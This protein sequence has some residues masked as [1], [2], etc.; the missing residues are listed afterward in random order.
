MKLNLISFFE[1]KISKEESY[2]V[3]LERW[4]K[5]TCEKR[6]NSQQICYHESICGRQVKESNSNT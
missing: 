3:K 1:L 5:V 4:I 2:M 6:Y